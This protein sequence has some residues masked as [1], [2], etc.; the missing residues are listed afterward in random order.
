MA[1]FTAVS[2]EEAAAFIAPLTLGRLVSLRGIPG[3]IENTNYFITT[4]AGEFVLT[5]FERPGDMQLSF[6]LQLMQHLARKGI[7]VPEPKADRDGRALF[8]LNEKE[9]CVVTK[10]AGSHCLE[11]E[12]IHC[13][14]VGEMLARMHR[15]SDDF[16][17][18]KGNGRG[19]HWWCETTDR[20]APYL[21]DERREVLLDELR[22][23]RAVAADNSYH[24]LPRGPVHCDLFRDNVLFSKVDGS[25]CSSRAEMLSGFFDFYF[26]GTD[27]LIFD[28]A[29]CLN[30]W[31]V[32]PPSGTPLPV[33][34][35]VF[36]SA[37]ERVRP[38]TTMEWRHLPSL[39]RA[40]AL[41]F[42]LSRLADLHFPRTSM[43]L[44][45]HDPEHFFRLMCRHRRSSAF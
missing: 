15:A 14:Q 16:P 17:L 5:L 25:G 12:A 2:E 6:S 26:S 28:L 31:C 23:Q 40:A 33:L 19:Y 36:V 7:P 39:L 38:L 4:Y 30:D 24:A 32:D 10:L 9:A 35:A 45:A 44:H 42:W 8:E 3:G 43:L 27:A 41:R 11:A 20:V 29:V 13:D 34:A 1:V 18:R 21:D 22:F 37:Y